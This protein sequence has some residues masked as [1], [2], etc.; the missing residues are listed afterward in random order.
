MSGISG[1]FYRLRLKMKNCLLRIDTLPVEGAKIALFPPIDNS[2][3]NGSSYE[4]VTVLWFGGAGGVGAT[5]NNTF[6][7]SKTFLANWG[8]TVLEAD[9][10]ANESDLWNK[11]V[12]T[13]TYWLQQNGWIASSRTFDW[14]R[15]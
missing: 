12:S 8:I 14:N 5:W 6:T 13:E 15:P 1:G 11:W 4:N 3:G 9:T 7:Q 10:D 2:T